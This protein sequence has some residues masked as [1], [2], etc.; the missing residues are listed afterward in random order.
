MSLMVMCA[1]GNA[2]TT[3]E[4]WVADGSEPAQHHQCE[5]ALLPNGRW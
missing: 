1:S 2:A 3:R 5:G 4:D